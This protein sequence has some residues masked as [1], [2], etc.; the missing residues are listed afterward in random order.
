MTTVLGLV[1]HH[2]RAEIPDLAARVLEWADRNGI[3]VSLPLTDAELIGRSDL[4]V[5]ENRFGDDVAVCLSLGGDGTMLRATQLVGAKGVPLMGVNAGRLGYLTE[6]DPGDLEYALEAW[7]A[8]RLVVEQ[9]MLLDVWLD[10]GT[11]LRPVPRAGDTGRVAADTNGEPVAFALNEVVVE[12]SE[13]GHTVNVSATISGSYFTRYLADGLIIATPTGSTAYSLS[14][15]GPIVE[16]DF[17]ALVMCPVASHTPFNRP[18]VLAPST[19]VRLTVEGFRAGIVTV[20]GQQIARLEPGQ[21]LI[22]RGGNR[23][24]TFLVSG[25]RDFHT[26]LKEKFGL[27]DR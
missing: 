4:G 17:E 1:V 14:A 16:P 11:L 7:R 13:S 24:A 12:R 21:S 26:I 22:C 27:T 20:D 5:D 9:R 6:V 10:G 19:E 2:Y 3:A 8:G 25:D 15:G 23:S 18:L